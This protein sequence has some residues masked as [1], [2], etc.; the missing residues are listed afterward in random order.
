M[1]RFSR[2]ISV[3]EPSALQLQC[4][5]SSDPLRRRCWWWWPYRYTFPL[6]TFSFTLRG[7]LWCIVGCN[8]FSKRRRNACQPTE[9]ILLFVLVF[10][11]QNV[12]VGIS[13]TFRCRWRRRR[14]NYRRNL[15]GCWRC[16]LRR[17][18]SAENISSLRMVAVTFALG[19][20]T[21]L[22]QPGGKGVGFTSSV[23]IAPNRRRRLCC[24][25]SCSYS[26]PVAAA[27][28]AGTAGGSNRRPMR[29]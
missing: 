5:I 19:C 20:R 9:C 6:D 21:V 24:G 18:Q 22:L 13:L 29:G 3:I 12:A 7:L 26:P 10:L 2:V 14:R 28:L 16:C 17:C 11:F 15:L 27:T 25:A 8:R 23:A 4:N 1:Y